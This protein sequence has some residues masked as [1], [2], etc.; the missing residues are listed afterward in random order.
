MRS[1]NKQVGKRISVTKVNFQSITSSTIIA[2]MMVI[3]CLKTS[4][5]TLVKAI[6]IM[7]VSLVIRDIRNPD[8][9]LLKKSIEWRNNLLNSGT[10]IAEI[11]L[12]LTHGGQEVRADEQGLRTV[13]IAG[14]A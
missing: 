11:T 6:C 1:G 9:I 7:R 8:R 3:G 13:M 5:L 14:M 12:L 2:P 4:L 10:R